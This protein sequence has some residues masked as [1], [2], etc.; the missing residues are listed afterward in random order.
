MFSVFLYFHFISTIYYIIHNEKVI[1]V[2]GLAEVEC[3]VLLALGS[4]AGIP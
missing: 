3:A 2:S 1:I 4:A